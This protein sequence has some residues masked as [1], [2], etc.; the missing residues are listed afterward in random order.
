MK[1]NPDPGFSGTIIIVR[2][3]YDIFNVKFALYL[4]FFVPYKVK[5]IS[6]LVNFMIEYFMNKPIPSIYY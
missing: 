4:P 1:K 6:L 3:V 2:L 5:V